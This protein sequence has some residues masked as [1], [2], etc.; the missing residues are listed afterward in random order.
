LTGLAGA[1]DNGGVTLYDD[2]RAALGPAGTDL[3]FI[4]SVGERDHPCGHRQHGRWRIDNDVAHDAGLNGGDAGID[5][6]TGSSGTFS[7][8][9]NTTVALASSQSWTNNIGS[10]FTANGSVTGAAATDVTLTTTGGITI[11]GAITSMVVIS[12]ESQGAGSNAV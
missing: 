5:I 11:A 4:A 9:S 1:L 3:R 2:A 12:R 8:N 6:T 10:T 7:F